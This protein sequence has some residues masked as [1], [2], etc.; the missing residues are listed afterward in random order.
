MRQLR[1]QHWV[2]LL[3]ALEAE[4][5]QVAGFGEVTVTISFHDGSPRDV[6]VRERLPHYRLGRKNIP[7]RDQQPT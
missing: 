6:R 5:A 3:A 1:D 7:L 4:A 2:D